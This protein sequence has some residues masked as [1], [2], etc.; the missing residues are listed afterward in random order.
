ME[1]DHIIFDV[2]S[3]ASFIGSLFLLAEAKKYKV[4]KTNHALY[5]KGGLE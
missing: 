3:I 2:V 1:L 4:R 5:I